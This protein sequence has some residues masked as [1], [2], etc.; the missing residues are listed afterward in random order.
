M[1]VKFAF[2]A[3]FAAF[4]LSGCATTSG[5]ESEIAA[6]DG[7]VQK[8]EQDIS[9]G[10]AEIG[11]PG[12][13][14]RAQI[15]YRPIISWADAFSARTAD[16]R[17]IR[18]RQTARDGDLY[19][20]E[21]EC[22]FS[23]PNWHRHDGKRAWIHESDSTKV[24]IEIGRFAVEPTASGLD[25]RAALEVDGKTQVGAN[26]RVACGPSVGGNIG[27]SAK[28]RPAALM[29]VVI[30]NGDVGTPQYSLA[31]V[32]PDTVGL[33]MRAHFN[34]FDVGFTIPIKNLARELAGGE[35]NL[36]L[37]KEGKIILPGGE[38]RNYRLATADPT[39]ATSIQGLS[40]SSD[41]TLIID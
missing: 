20:R 10:T 38:V 29:R 6:I 3:F 36:L 21:H 22:R 30:R 32:S 24:N 15:S 37:S 25:L 23:F 19:K 17:T 18:F 12:K 8:V 5:L 39:V 13:D 28:A 34:W 33:E 9:T 2:A 7:R 41:V 16:D 27:A 1:R 35:L 40:F 31:V 14:V 4:G 26:F 11:A